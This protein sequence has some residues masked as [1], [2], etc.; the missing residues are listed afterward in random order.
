MR[1]VFIHGFGET[2][3]VFDQIAPKLSGEHTYVSL[4]EALGNDPRRNLRISD[5]SQELIDKYAIVP[6]DLVIGHSLGG[7]IAYHIKQLQ[8]NRI[9]QLASWT[10][11]VRVKMPIKNPNVALWLARWGLLF[12]PVVKRYLMKQ[13]RMPQSVPYYESALDNL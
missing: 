4:W 12:N 7:K 5:F 10:Q 3:E 9:V 8:N 2:A 1:I 6:E 11:Q 13:Y